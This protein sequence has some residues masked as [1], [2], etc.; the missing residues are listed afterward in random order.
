M[1]IPIGWEYSRTLPVTDYVK[2]P[3][4]YKHFVLSE[5]T[6]K[7]LYQLLP[8]LAQKSAVKNDLTWVCIQG[9]KVSLHMIGRTQNPGF[10]VTADDTELPKKSPSEHRCTHRGP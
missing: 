7:Y 9:N 4:V 10:R 5:W 3:A 6:L 8:H 1:W 2:L